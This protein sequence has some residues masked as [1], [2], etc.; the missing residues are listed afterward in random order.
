MSFTLVALMLSAMVSADPSWTK[1]SKEAWNPIQF[2]KEWARRH[3][4]LDTSTF[5][6]QTIN[7]K[8]WAMYTDAIMNGNQYSIVKTGFY[9]DTAH[10]TED[11]ER[12]LSLC[13]AD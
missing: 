11:K 6:A 12:C 2:S 3:R 13:L 10:R 8:V 5:V 1:L 4:N 7:G 9:G